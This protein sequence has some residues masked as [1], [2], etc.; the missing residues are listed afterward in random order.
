MPRR[1]RAR[2]RRRLRLV[3]QAEREHAAQPREHVDAPG[4]VSAQHHFGVGP[5]GE[6]VA[7]RFELLF[8]REEVVGL[9]VVGDARRTVVAAH[10]LRA[11]VAHVQDREPRVTENRKRLSIVRA[12]GRRKH[13]LAI[14]STMRQRGHH[15][16]HRGFRIAPRDPSAPEHAAGNA[17][18][19]RLW[20]RSPR[21]SRLPTS[22]DPRRRQAFVECRQRSG[23]NRPRKARRQTAGRLSLLRAFVRVGHGFAQA[24]RDRGAVG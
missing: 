2:R 7:A 19:I 13:A 20:T 11:G 9:A 23:D 18:H 21:A 24:G 5:A 14:R 12:S 22:D 16:R 15:R 8:Q 17:A 1:S 3:P 10:R 4:V 6:A